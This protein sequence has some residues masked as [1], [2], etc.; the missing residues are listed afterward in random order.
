MQVIVG[1]PIQRNRRSVKKVNPVADCGFYL[2]EISNCPA[3]LRRSIGGRAEMRRRKEAASGKLPTLHTLIIKDVHNAWEKMW[4]DIDIF[5]DVQRSFPEEEE[6]LA[7]AALNACLSA[8]N[9]EHWALSRWTREQ[10]QRG[11]YSDDLP[12]RELLEEMVPQ[13]G[14]CVDVANTTKHGGHRNIRWPN[15]ELKLEYEEANEHCPP[16]Y[17][18]RSFH[19][20]KTSYLYNDLH[21]LPRLWWC[22]LAK[23]D[24]VSGEQPTPAWWSRK[25]SRIFGVAHKIPPI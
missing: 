4:W 6:P 9:L 22:F 2:Q 11:N 18:V 25:M 15:G 12:F 10:R 23:I 20:R 8:S 3:I 7:Y 16:G 1:V 19:E 21:D 17:T 14:L 24:L 13:Q 5:G